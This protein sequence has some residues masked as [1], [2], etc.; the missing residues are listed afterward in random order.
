MTDDADFDADS[1]LADD[2]RAFAPRRAGRMDAAD[3]LAWHCLSASLTAAQRRR[4]RR[5]GSL[6]LVVEAP[7]PD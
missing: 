3:T 1:D 5:P 2:A 4:L 6:A 7:G